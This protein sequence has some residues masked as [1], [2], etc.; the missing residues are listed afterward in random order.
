VSGEVQEAKLLVRVMPQYPP[1]AR[2]ARIQG[3]VRLSA[4][5]DK[6]GKIVELKLLQGNPLLVDS[7]L[8]A[9]GRWRYR[10]TFLNGQAVEVATWINVDFHLKQ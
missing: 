6:D 2:Q 8:A 1:L 3:I 5:I 9:I 10:P 7:A 4:I